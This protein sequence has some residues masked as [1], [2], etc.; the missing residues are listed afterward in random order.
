MGP[1]AIGGD[2]A[3]FD[4]EEELLHCLETAAYGSGRGAGEPR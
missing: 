4:L 2:K 3:C 1:T